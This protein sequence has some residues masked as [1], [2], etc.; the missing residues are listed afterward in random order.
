M[1]LYRFLHHPPQELPHR[2]LRIDVRQ[3]PLELLQATPAIIIDYRLE[4]PPPRAKRPHPI[5]RPRQFGI[6]VGQHFLHL[7]RALARRPRHQRLPL[8]C[9]QQ[10]RRIRFRYRRRSV[11]RRS[12]GR[13]HRPDAGLRAATAASLLTLLPLESV[14]QLRRRVQRQRAVL[15]PPTRPFHLYAQPHRLDAA[16]SGSVAVTEFA[17]RV[18]EQA[19]KAEG[20]IQAAPLK[21]AQVVDH[22]HF[23]VLFDGR[24]LLDPLQQ[25]LIGKRGHGRRNRHVL[26]YVT[27][28]INVI[29][30][31]T[32]VKQSIKFRAV[33][34]P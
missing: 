34:S 15:N 29:N 24:Q 16:P 14:L 28:A 32:R 9:A 31:S 8:R 2:H 19:G 30:E 1:A 21:L 17:H 6:H 12:V 10:R 4:L 33:N 20:Q 18:L 25:T 27:H 22:D 26:S 11:R 3:Q 23:E 13:W 5:S 7:P